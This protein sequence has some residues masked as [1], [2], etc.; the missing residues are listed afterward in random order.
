MFPQTTKD[1]DEVDRQ[2]KE[3]FKE[4]EMQKNF[5]RQ[6]KLKGNTGNIN[7]NLKCSNQ[8]VARFVKVVYIDITLSGL[9]H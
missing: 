2:R 6:E 1:L 5:E 8:H 4:Y 7:N 3:E 9:L